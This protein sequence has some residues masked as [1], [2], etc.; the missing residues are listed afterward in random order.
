[1]YGTFIQ[2]H[3]DPQDELMGYMLRVWQN[4]VPQQLHNLAVDRF[5]GLDLFNSS[6]YGH[7]AGIKSRQAVS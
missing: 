5:I 6:L 1:M 2:K 4:F 3:D 7:Y